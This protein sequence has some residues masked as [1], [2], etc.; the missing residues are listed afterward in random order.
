M[1]N[2]LIIF[3]GFVI[4]S[5]IINKRL[6][7]KFKKYSKISLPQG[8][9]GKDIAEKML[10]ENNIKDVNVTSVKGSLTD[11]YNPLKKTVNLSSSVYNNSSIA[12]AAVAAHECGHAVQHANA[13]SWLQMR[14]K[15]VP[16]I[17]FTSKCI[18]GSRRT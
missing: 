10:H 5:S 3:I 1:W 2:I 6:K 14:S 13:Y 7:S 16:V 15:L 12:A 17:E 18:T 11:H 8:I 9:T 4:I